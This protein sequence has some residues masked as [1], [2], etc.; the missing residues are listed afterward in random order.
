MLVD[1]KDPVQV[2]LLT[3]TALFDSREY[4][5]LSQEEADDLKKQV[6]YLNSVIATTRS[7]LA[8]QSKYRDAAVSMT[9]LYSPTQPRRKSLLGNR[10]SSGSDA[11]AREAETERVT[12][13]QK[14]EELATELW[15]LERR[16][17]DPQRRLLEHTAGILQLTHKAPKKV[18]TP[19]PK[20]PL[21]NGVPASPESMYTLSNGRNSFE[22]DDALV[23]DE[24]SLYRSFDDGGF[25]I[26]TTTLEVKKDPVEI[27]MR[28]P[29][30]D[31]QKQLT[32]E[33]EKL[34]DENTQLQQ[35]IE[36]L[37]DENTQLQEAAEGLRDENAELRQ[38]TESLRMQSSEIKE[39]RNQSEGQERLITD[40]EQKLEVSNSELQRIIMQADPV[41]FAEYSAL[42][43][44]QLEPGD[45][46]ASQLEYLQKAVLV[47]N[48]NQGNNRK[49]TETVYDLGCQ[50]QNLL[51]SNGDKYADPPT[52]DSGFEEQVSYIR[53]GCSDLEGMIQKANGQR[54]A[55]SADRQK[56]E[57]TEAVLMFLWDIIH[58]G[59]ADIRRRREDRQKMRIEKGLPNDEEDS[60]DSESFDPDETYSL[61]AFSAKVQ[62]LYAEATKLKEQ[63]S[64]LKRQIKQQREL[65]N[66]S[67]SEKDEALSNKVSE[68][69]KTRASLDRVEREAVDMRRELSDALANLETAR[70]HANHSGQE[71]SAAIK[72]AHDKLMER[73]SKINSLEASTQDMQI[74]LAAAEANI[75]VITAQLQEANNA[76]DEAERVVEQKKKEI[77]TKQDEL[78]EMTGMVAEFKMEATFAKAELDGAYGSRR[79]R[80]AEVAAM[81]NSSEMAKLQAK[82]DRMQP[83]IAELEK[84]LQGTVQDLK[85]ITKQ[86]IEAET[87]IADLETELD[88]AAQSAR[89]EKEQLQE[90]LD[91]ER[92]KGNNIP[93]SPSGRPNASILTDSYRDA[94]RKERKKHE[95]QLRVC[96]L[97]SQ[98]ASGLTN[99]SLPQNEQMNR[100]KLEEELRQLRRAVGPGRSP[101]SPSALSSNLSPTPR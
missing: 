46:M 64:V 50:I 14:C 26:M 18:A 67:D 72:E 9:K 22:R 94:L 6:R 87:K 59:Y 44:G 37:R 19:T 65:N 24:G 98:F 73:N 38:E 2:H 100:R 80:A 86:A 47:V 41:K 20:T 71:Q 43:S 42:P 89:R 55:S 48:E 90:A 39:L 83:R 78:D 11:A 27:P 52:V 84:E 8:I 31:Q 12:I 1:L 7:K 91:H 21:V 69:E 54:L 3:E 82:H 32:E 79:E 99:V 60:S 75:A 92:L 76:R 66:K 23:F 56:G 25:D 74:R 35:A 33:T 95:E 58:S 93:V 57:Q 96:R 5:V 62:W 49:A 17:M 68:L 29:I 97:R 45:M 30:R 77:S 70:N 85:D 15:S 101:F 4:E 40:A 53:T 61:N 10:S 36:M 51:G 88:R 13:Q 81:A 63:K 34:R 28:S 16:V